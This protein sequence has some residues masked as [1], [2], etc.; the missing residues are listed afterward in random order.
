MKT[1]T[2]AKRDYV[3]DHLSKDLKS[4][5]IRL[6]ALTRIEDTIQSKSPD[7]LKNDNLFTKYDKNS[8]ELQYLNWKSY[9]LNGAEKSVIVGLF[10]FSK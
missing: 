6:N 7:L 8:F 9:D 10:K 5:T 4:P 3:K 2:E 1:Y